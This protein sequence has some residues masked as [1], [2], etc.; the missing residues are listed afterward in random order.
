M[1]GGEIVAIISVSIAGCATLLTTCFHSRCVTIDWCWGGIKCTRKVID[2][3]NELP[4]V[5]A[6]AVV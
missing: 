2:D 4:Q 5:E 1:L 6:R 3:E